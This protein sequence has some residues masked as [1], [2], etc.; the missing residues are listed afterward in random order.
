MHTQR[1]HNVAWT[2]MQLHDAAPTSMERRPNAAR[3]FGT[4]QT[5]NVATSPR[6]RRDPT[7]SPDAETT[8][9]RCHVPDDI[10]VTKIMNIY[11]IMRGR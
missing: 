6:S 9:L 1:E 4:K 10:N 11:I 2:P 3:P 7:M 5:H 8:P